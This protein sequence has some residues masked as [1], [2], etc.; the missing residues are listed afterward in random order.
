[1]NSKDRVMLAINH[2]K[3]DRVPVDFWCE[4][5]VKKSL[6]D[7]LKLDNEDELLTKFKIDIRNVYPK[8]V[9]PK[10]KTFND[11]SYE[12]FWGVIR[13]PVKNPY[14]VH[15]E[16]SYYPLNEDLTLKKIE[17]YKW[18][19]A[20]WFDYDSLHEQLNKYKDFA[21]CVGKMGTECQTFFIQTW[22]LR[23]LNEILMDMIINPDAVDLMISKIL[24]FRKEH[25]KEILKVL[26]GRA[27]WVQLADDYGM[28]K[29]LFFSLEFWKRY[30]KNPIKEIAEI[31]HNHG[32][33][34]FLHSCGSV[35]ELIPEFIAA[36]ID[37][38]NPIQ[39]MAKSMD[40]VEIKKEYGEKICMHG[41]MDTQKILNFGSEED[42]I[43]EVNKKIDRLS[44]GGG[45]I[46]S[47]THTIE[48]DIPIK[49][50]IAMYKAVH[51]FY[52][53]RF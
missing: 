32:I 11:G 23:G 25:L 5:S 49:N 3:P 28:Q 22:Y 14:G 18:P 45:F 33:K 8:Y 19:K 52:G 51:N 50:I 9:G 35:R 47:T 38:L 36:G 31:I 34:V 39:V 26:K 16:V 41:T 1:M 48:P 12:D 42:I 40:P 27:A 53:Q 21:I 15:Y 46:L 2:I 13:K 17:Q 30:F 6:M 4:N 24:D 10:L 44:D 43:K 7:F 20:E 37:I 29:G